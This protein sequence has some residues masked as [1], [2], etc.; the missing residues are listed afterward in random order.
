MLICQLGLIAVITTQV[1]ACRN[2]ESLRIMREGPYG[3]NWGITWKLDRAIAKNPDDAG[4]YLNRG[5]VHSQWGRRRKAIE[6]FSKAIQYNPNNP[7]VFPDLAEVYSA[8]AQ[9]HRILRD[10]QKA[11]AD[12]QKAAEIYKQ[13]GDQQRYKSTLIDIEW[14]R[15]SLP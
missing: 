8:R 11:I 10:R 12:Y 4:A 9:E 2:Y 5:R 1:T 14:V 7:E 15:Q 6:D 3:A 13:H